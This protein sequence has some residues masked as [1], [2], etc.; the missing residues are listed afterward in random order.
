MMYKQGT[1]LFIVLK[2][3]VLVVKL[4]IDGNFYIL[5]FFLFVLHP[6][7]FFAF[8][9]TF[10][11][12]SS[13]SPMLH[14][15]FSVAVLRRVATFAGFQFML[16]CFGCSTGGTKKRIGCGGGF[17]LIC[18]GILNFVLTFIFHGRSLSN[19]NAAMLC[20]MCLPAVSLA[21]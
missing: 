8:L 16:G 21:C 12:V 17:F 4:F 11:S 6:L 14:L 10:C 9:F 3:L 7:L 15:T 19:T 20:S 1:L 13:F 2:L 18:T 5:S